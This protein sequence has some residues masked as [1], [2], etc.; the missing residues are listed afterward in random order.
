[1]AKD[2][3]ATLAA[4]LDKPTATLLVTDDVQTRYFILETALTAA[5]LYL[6]KRYADKYL[7]GLG[8]DAMAKEH[9]K[10]TKEFMQKVRAGAATAS[11]ID[12]GK[13]ELAT[14][15]ATIKSSPPNQAAQTAAVAAVESALIESGGVRAQARAVAVLVSQTAMSE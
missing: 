4:Q 9:G 10:K 3:V 13:A 7:E 5:A 6:L 11:D 8:F 12:A 15:I 2:P 1:M 14:A